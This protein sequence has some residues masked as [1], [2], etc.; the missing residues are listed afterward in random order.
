MVPPVQAGRSVD[1]APAQRPLRLENEVDAVANRLY[2]GRAKVRLWVPL[3]VIAGLCAIA[4]LP[5][6]VSLIVLILAGIVLGLDVRRH[7]QAFEIAERQVRERL[8]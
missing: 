8:R 1:E 3:I 5:G 6:V 4:G 2:S 7:I